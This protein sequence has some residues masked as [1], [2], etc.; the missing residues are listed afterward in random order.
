MRAVLSFLV[1]SL[2]LCLGLSSGA[3]A[4]VTE[5]TVT[6]DGQ[7]MS[8]DDAIQNALVNAAGQAFGVRLSAQF[9][10][11]TIAADGSVDN[12]DH[13][14]VMNVLNKNI[15]QVLNAPQNAPILGYDV[16]NAA[17][18][19]GHGWEASVTLRYAKYERLGSDSNRRSVVVVSSSRQFRQQLIQGISQSLVGTRRFDVLNRE[20]DQLFQNEKDFILGDAAANP[21]IARLSQ[22]SGADYLVVAQLQNLGVSNNQR[23]TIAM[24]G[25][26]LVNSAASG[27]LQLQVIEF[28]SRKVKWVGSQRFGGNYA[29][30]TSVGAGAL[31]GLI[32]GASD[33]LV[34]RMID[35]IYPMQVIKVMG[36]TAIVNRGE[37]GISAGETFAVFQVGEELRDPQSGESL[38]PIETEVGLG[39]VTEVK[40]KFSFLK[41][42]SGTLTEGASYIVRKTDKRPMAAA[43]ARS[44]PKRSTAAAAPRKSTEPD[45]ASVF[46]NN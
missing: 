45:R 36:D 1:I 26:V 24:T 27:T 21:E 39:R 23:E 34:A 37:G 22:A 13:S 38:G 33:K 17:E 19:P 30:A 8:R 4:Q 18:N 2:T 20:N 15:Q 28:A 9:G 42:A 46:L 35:A 43:A 40:P 12:Q 14:A 41:M 11:Q 44:A 29:G 5:A 25:E 7:G 10:T 16:N 6:A 32:S 31:A 3:R